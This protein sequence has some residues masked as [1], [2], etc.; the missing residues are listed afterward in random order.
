MQSVERRLLAAIND[1]DLDEARRALEAGADLSRPP[2]ARFVHR[3]AAG[4]SA[5]MAALLLDFGADIE[6]GDHEG[7]TALTVADAHENW[8]VAELLERRGADTSRR[9]AHGFT[10]LHRAVRRGDLAE[11]ERLV[12]HGAVDPMATPGRTPLL[13]AISCRHEPIAAR[14]LA[15]GADPNAGD[16]DWSLL[17]EAVH[18]DVVR[19]Q[20]TNFTGLLLDAGADPNPP[21]YPPILMAV[22]QSGA[23]SDLI[24][25]LHSAG[26]NIDARTP[27]GNSSVL[28]LIA[29]IYDDA[30]LVATA[31][32]CGAPLEATDDEGRTPLLVAAART[33]AVVVAALL[34]AG[35]DPTARDRDGRCA[36]ELVHA[37]PHP[38]FG[39]ADETERLLTTRTA[40][41]G[42]AAPGLPE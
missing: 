2:A 14:L 10:P 5:E 22:D 21:G 40:E 41:P 13:E 28:H 23:R 31:L 15:M 11:V 9:T 12:A 8:A 17:T 37:D 18:Q 30:D 34:A 32:A 25:R 33:N 1:D 35:A 29:A 24:R 36:I 39:G 20:T 6:L 3:V 38:A 4:G 16:G 42:H 27:H 7:W 19:D 26:A